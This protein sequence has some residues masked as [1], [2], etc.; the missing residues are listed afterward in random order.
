MNTQAWIMI[1]AFLTIVLLTQIGRK[2]F[3]TTKAVLP[4]I[5]CGISV[6]LFVEE[7]PTSGSNMTAL[8]I[9]TMVGMIMGGIMLFTVKVEYGSDNKAYV[10]AGIPYLCLWIIGLGWRVVLAYV[11]TDWY[12][13][14]FIDF[15]VSNHLDFNV[16][17][18]AFVFFTIAM[19]VIRTI[20]I[21]I[22]I[23][24]YRKNQKQ[25]KE[26]G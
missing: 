1:G 7:I 25:I 5:L 24:R 22:R 8:I 21:V 14:Q 3:T 20:G 15:M 19:V 17:A 13:Q 6:Y 12:P 2:V 23:Q 18:P 16:I 10:T 11:A 4:F 9:M 26:I